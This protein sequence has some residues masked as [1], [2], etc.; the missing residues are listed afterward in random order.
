MQSLESG[1]SY[2]EDSDIE[3]APE[4]HPL[5][6]ALQRAA[7]RRDEAAGIREALEAEA[8]QV[9]QLAVN[10]ESSLISTKKLLED[11]LAEL[12]AAIITQSKLEE[13][14]IDVTARLREQ[15]DVSPMQG[16]EALAGEETAIEEKSILPTLEDKLW[17]KS[18]AL[19]AATARIKELESQIVAYK[20]KLSVVEGTYAKADAIASAAMEAAEQAVKDEMECITVYKE[21][22]MALKKAVKDLRF[23]LNTSERREEDFDRKVLVKSVASIIEEEE[24]LEEM[25]E[26]EDED[27]V[28]RDGE[29]TKRG[30]KAKQVLVLARRN[31]VW[32]A[33]GIILLLGAVMFAHQQG[34]IEALTSMA[35]MGIGQLIKLWSAALGLFKRL[36]LPHIHESEAGLLETIWLLLASVITVPLVCKLPGGSP[37][38]GFL[39]GGALIG[40]YAL[41]IIQDVES[42]RHLAELGVVFLLFNIGL[43]LSFDRLRSMGKYVFGMGTAQVVLTLVGVAYTAL[44]VTGGAL[45]GPGSIILG[46]GLAL[47]TTAV[48]MQVLQD[49]GE[50]GSRHG[51]AAFSVLL[52]QDL[53]VVVLLML[54]PL[55]APSADGSSAAGL[56]KIFKAIGF[57]SVKA[58]ACMVSIVVA[59]RTVLQPLYRRVADTK[60]SDVFAALTLLVVLGTSLITQVAGLSL[61]LGAFLAGLLLAETDY[62]LQVESD[63]APYKGILMGLFFMTVGMEFSVTLLIAKFKT[64]IAATILLIG[65]K[66][67]IMTAVG[68]AFGLSLVQSIRSGL[69]L[70]PGGEFAFVLFGEAMARGIMSASLVR[71]LFLVVA[72][73][74]ALTPF[75]ADFGA[76]IA[77][78]LER[79]DMGALQPKEGEMSGMSGHVIIA[80]FG[81]AGQLISQMLSEQLIPFVALDS[82]PGKVQEGKALDLPVYFGD[83]GSPAVLHAIG[84]DRAAC[85]VIT[86]DTPGSNYRS[87]YAMH[88]HFPHVKTYVRARDIDSAIMLERAGAT[89]VVPEI[90]EPS[91]QLGAAVLSE[92]DLPEDEVA[93]VIR[94]FRKGHLAELQLLANLSGT[95][96]GYGSI[97]EN[98]GDG[99]IDDGSTVSSEIATAS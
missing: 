3:D 77:K 8:Q 92:L 69:L 57:A 91:L 86:L 47:S 62:H 95:S 4:L 28:G 64:V 72:L 90:L 12:E 38:L 71:E 35:S 53:A 13:Q 82:S 70:S 33:G 80:G 87:V 54:V 78:M 46:G 42:I 14:V 31:P 27:M 97:R 81:R 22:E 16:N 37:V 75:L 51:R 60:N 63:I 15:L 56:G 74:M 50:T 89:A 23:M 55:L 21:T 73:S 36:P 17:E 5:T 88:K 48:G 79:S 11:A 25:L 84:A 49:R 30:N 45:N 20:A 96:L 19:G 1:P 32:T 61:A 94:S 2:D 99:E 93:D 39:A 10:A 98:E 68:Q 26:D 24:E 52:L 6:E 65:G 67:A 58:V 83:A 29:K 59:G 41:G 85:A 9:A 40:P 34:Y 7:N 18:Q 66:V 43:E 44:A 76:R